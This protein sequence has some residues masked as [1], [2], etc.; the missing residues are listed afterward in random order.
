M[1]LF[2]LT[3]ALQSDI[4]I[5]LHKLYRGFLRGKSTL[6][7]GVSLIS[8]VEADLCSNNGGITLFRRILRGTLF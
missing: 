5:L 8:P 4:I 1:C 7:K 3:N 2:L 6:V